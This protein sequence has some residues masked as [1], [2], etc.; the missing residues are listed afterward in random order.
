MSGTQ[1][2][3]FF[4]FMMACGVFTVGTCKLDDASPS[5]NLIWVQDTS[6]MQSMATLSS[7]RL[8]CWEASCGRL[9]TYFVN[10]EALND[11]TGNLMSVPIIKCI[12]ISLGLLIW[13]ATNM[14]IGCEMFVHS[15][16][17]SLF[18]QGGALVHSVGL[19]WKQRSDP[20]TSQ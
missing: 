9:V 6:S 20:W 10:A 2:G 16:I 8:L 14:M 4:Q 11:A 5:T 7:S 18:P 19:I 15:C 17:D 12:G 3:M 13:G 1:D